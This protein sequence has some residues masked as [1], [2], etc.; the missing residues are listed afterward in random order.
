MSD[1]IYH[2]TKIDRK[3]DLLLNVWGIDHS[4]YV[5]RIKNAITSL[6]GNDFEFNIELTALVNLIQN[7]KP[8]KMSKRKG[9]LLP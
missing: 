3:Y 6:F 7:K 8:I 2:S 5:K 1:I 4:G 9:V